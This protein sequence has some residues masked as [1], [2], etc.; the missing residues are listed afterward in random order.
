MIVYGSVCME[1]LLKFLGLWCVNVVV[2]LV[3]DLWVVMVWQW[4]WLVLCFFFFFLILLCFSGGGSLDGWLLM[5]GLSFND[6][7]LLAFVDCQRW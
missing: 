3:G 2:V 5:I 1:I 6:R 4:W 7:W